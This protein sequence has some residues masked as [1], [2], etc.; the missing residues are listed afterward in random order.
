MSNLLSFA[1][2]VCHVTHPE[3]GPVARIMLCP[4]GKMAVTSIKPTLNH[5]SINFRG[6]RGLA[7]VTRVAQASS[8]L[9]T[10]S[11]N[12]NGSSSNNPTR[13][14]ASRSM[15]ATGSPP[16]SGPDAAAAGSVPN[17]ITLPAAVVAQAAGWLQTRQVLRGA[18]AAAAPKVGA[19]WEAATAAAAT[20]A[21]PGLPVVPLDRISPQWMC[22]TLTHHMPIRTCHG[23]LSVAHDMSVGRCWLLHHHLCLQATTPGLPLPAFI[24]GTAV[25]GAGAVL[26]TAMAA[27]A[28]SPDW[29]QDAAFF[30]SVLAGLWGLSCW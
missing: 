5:P 26:L 16:P 28:V 15:F 9:S 24:R 12:V 22:I 27:T 3:I 13:P 1:C 30:S 17:S 18:A 7:V 2:R 21:C 6:E 4:P 14:E 10:A 20:A 25:F 8:S 19:G 23:H 29:Q 11:L